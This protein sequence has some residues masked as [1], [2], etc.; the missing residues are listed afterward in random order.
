MNSK[1]QNN[2]KHPLSYADSRFE[3]IDE[4]TIKHLSQSVSELTHF[5]KRLT[6]MR[7]YEHLSIKSI[8]EILFIPYFAVEIL[9]LSINNVLQKMLPDHHPDTLYFKHHIEAYF[10]E[11]IHKDNPIEH[12]DVEKDLAQIMYL[13]QR[14][15]TT[16]SLSNHHNAT[17]TELKANH[18]IV[19]YPQ[20]WTNKSYVM[21][22]ESS[23]LSNPDTIFL[24]NGQ[25]LKGVKIRGGHYFN[26]SEN[27][28]FSIF[29]QGCLYHKESINNIDR[30]LPSFKIA[31]K[32]DQIII[33]LT[34]SLSGIDLTSIILTDHHSHPITYELKE[35]S[36]VFL[37]QSHDRIY[38]E[39]KDNA[40]NRLH[41]LIHLESSP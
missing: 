41:S 24:F 28:S 29:T 16:S 2:I 13:S 36:I 38:L 9:I 5:Q 1:H 23:D 35:A 10:D 11:E 12:R 32:N 6:R 15:N 3:T 37:K 8:S 26:I 4:A 18:S 7:Y 25:I 19:D 22:V 31:E 34:D 21:R 33:H 30:D 40:G 27:G 17:Y 14:P 20:D 39:V